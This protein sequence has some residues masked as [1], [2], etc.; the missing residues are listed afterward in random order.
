M[1]TANSGLKDSF[2]VV[3]RGDTLKKVATGDRFTG[4]PGIDVQMFISV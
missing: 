3:I 1:A 2:V 4:E